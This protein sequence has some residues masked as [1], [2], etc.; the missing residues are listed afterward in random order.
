M[1]SSWHSTTS[2]PTASRSPLLHFGGLC[3]VQYRLRRMLRRVV[4]MS[5]HLSL[6]QA[7]GQLTCLLGVRSCL[8]PTLYPGS[9]IAERFLPH[10]PEGPPE[11]RPY[12]DADASRLAIS[13]TGHWDLTPFL[14]PELLMPFLEPLVLRGIATRDDPFPDTS[15]DSSRE[16]LKLCQLW[17]SLGLLR[18]FPGPREAREL[19]RVFGSFKDAT[20]DRMIGD[21]RGPNSLEGGVLGVSKDLP[22]GA[23]LTQLHCPR[24]RVLVGASTDRSDFY[25]QI[26]VTRS[27]A[28]TNC[29]GPSLRLS[30]FSCP[31]PL[32]LPPALE[33][34][35]SRASAP[36]DQRGDDLARSS[37][38]FRGPDPV[39]HGAFGSLCQGDRCG[40]EYATQG[41][42]NL[43]RNNGLL[44]DSTRVVA[45]RPAAPG[46]LHDALI[47]DDYFAISADELGPALDFLGTHSSRLSAALLPATAFLQQNRPTPKPPCEDLTPRTTSAQWTSPWQARSSFLICPPVPSAGP[48]SAPPFISAS[49]LPTSPCRL[50]PCLP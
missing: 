35:S 13:D 8:P 22:S 45:A 46:P 38:C 4:A 9:P 16:A 37:A 18:E 17:D 14:E 11:L 20:R 33:E 39:V 6:P 49:H 32:D 26:A 43:L 47:I 25:H 19:C 31:A 15:R 10:R 1:S 27:R 12:R 48:S 34:A 7:A 28:A 40:V 50:L 23:S 30:Q 29:I 2:M 21:R 36:R 3:G 41:H 42:E 5:T 44:G 24:G